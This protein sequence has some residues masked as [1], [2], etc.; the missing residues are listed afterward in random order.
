MILWLVISSFRND[1][2]VTGILNQIHTSDEQIFDRILIAEE[3]GM[4]PCHIQLL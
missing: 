2:A 3:Q 4:G 1:E